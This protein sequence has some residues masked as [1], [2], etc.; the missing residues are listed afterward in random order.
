M[1]IFDFERDMNDF[2]RDEVAVNCLTEEDAVH[3]LKILKDE[4]KIKQQNDD[5][6]IY[7]EK[8][9]KDT[10]YSSKRLSYSDIGWYN[11]NGYK[12]LQYS[13]SEQKTTEEKTNIEENINVVQTKKRRIFILEG[14]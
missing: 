4:Y 3:F 5:D 9:E 12:V 7:W 6:R 8:Y 14:E 13:I 2:L 10:C 1:E 11:S